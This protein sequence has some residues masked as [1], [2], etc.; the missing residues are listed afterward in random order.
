MKQTPLGVTLE[1]NELG[2]S[3]LTPQPKKLKGFFISCNTL[4]I[5]EQEQY[6][7]YNPVGEET[8]DRNIINEIYNKTS[9]D[10]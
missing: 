8:F 3:L 5:E 1:T 4:A 7:D 6:I 9:A 2:Q 10:L